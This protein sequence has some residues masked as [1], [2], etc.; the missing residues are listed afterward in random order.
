MFWYLLVCTG[1]YSTT[2]LPLQAMPSKA[3]CEFVA[4]RYRTNAYAVRPR[5]IGTRERIL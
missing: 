5:C 2:C 3:T 1:G 4:E